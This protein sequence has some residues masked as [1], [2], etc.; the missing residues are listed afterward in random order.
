MDEEMISLMK[1][2]SELLYLPWWMS[3]ICFRT[4]DVGAISRMWTHRSRVVPLLSPLILSLPSLG[5]VKVELQI[6][7]FWAA[8]AAVTL[9]KIH[10]SEAV[11]AN[12]HVVYADSRSPSVGLSY[13]Q[14][15][16]FCFAQRNPRHTVW[17]DYLSTKFS[18]IGSSRRT[19]LV[20]TVGMWLSVTSTVR[21]EFRCAKQNASHCKLFK[22]CVGG[23]WKE[24]NDLYG[25]ARAQGVGL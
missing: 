1:S 6:L 21:C 18:K 9:C 12:G 2:R 8:A 24:S 3:F 4:V 13:L 15:L 14:W 5:A 22:K 23:A 7:Q 17:C 20:D 11:H 16:A 10:T 19:D 25:C